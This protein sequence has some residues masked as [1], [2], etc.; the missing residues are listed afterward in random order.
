VLDKGRTNLAVATLY[1]R[2]DAWVKPK[3]LA[4]CIDGFGN[5]FAGSGMRRMALHDDRTTG[6]KRGRGVATRG[7]EGER[8][9]RCAED[10]DG[11]NRALHQAN[12]RTRR[13]LAIR[14]GGVV[15]PIKVLAGQDMLREQAQL[16]G[17]AASLA[18]QA[19]FRQAGLFRADLR[20]RIGA[21]IDFISD[22]IKELGASGR[23]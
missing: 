7:R 21:G 8:E 19:T 11:T 9:V 2:E 13:R 17:G 12:V 23:R 18:D 20:D 15:A 4:C 5:D 6:G 3:L 14:Q 16:A 1:E 22:R 10:G